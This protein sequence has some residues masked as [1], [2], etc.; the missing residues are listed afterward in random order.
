MKKLFSLLTVCLLCVGILSGCVLPVELPTIQVTQPS[1]EHEIDRM[2]LD[3]EYAENP[4][5]VR[6]E[7]SDAFTGQKDM[8]DATDVTGLE[9]GIVEEVM[10][11]SDFGH[12]FSGTYLVT[13]KQLE[14]TT[15]SFERSSQLWEP[16]YTGINYYDLIMYGKAMDCEEVQITYG[17][18][19]KLVNVTGDFS[20]FLFTLSDNCPMQFGCDIVTVEGT[21]EEPATLSLVWDG[22]KFQLYSDIPLAKLCVIAEPANRQTEQYIILPEACIEYTFRIVDGVPVNEGLGA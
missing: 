19:V 14:D 21:T 18:E 17:K 2:L 11:C 20:I 15:V 22:E 7:G 9:P 16:L 1:A 8:I 6:I 4:V 5:F 3:I 12:Y 13:G 10:S